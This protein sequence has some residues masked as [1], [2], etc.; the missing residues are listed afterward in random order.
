MPEARNHDEPGNSPKDAP[1]RYE[2]VQP[3]IES[4][5]DFFSQRSITDF[6]NLQS[7]PILKAGIC[8]RFNNRYIVLGWQRRY[9]ASIDTVQ[10]SFAP[11][12]RSA[13][14]LPF[15]LLPS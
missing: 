12:A 1:Y 6:W 8:P 7:L 9:R 15:E 10:I 13:V 11:S 14:R 2:I 5:V 4:T 3:A